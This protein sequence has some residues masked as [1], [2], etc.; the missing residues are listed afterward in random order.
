MPDDMPVYAPV[1]TS[2]VP[3]PLNGAA[4]PAGQPGSFRDGWLEEL[5]LDTFTVDGLTGAKLYPHRGQSIWLSPYG[6]S[7]EDQEALEK[8]NAL[9]A[10]DPADR[11]ERQYHMLM[12]M[13][14]RLVV[15]WNITDARGVAYPPPAG[16]DDVDAFK[17]LPSKLVAHLLTLLRGE[18]E[19]NASGA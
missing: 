2:S 19:G 16:E 3:A 18:T 8:F 6:M 4:A 12:S 9:E 13:L 10:T 5:K 15:T 14:A 11:V 7:L 1:M 17:R